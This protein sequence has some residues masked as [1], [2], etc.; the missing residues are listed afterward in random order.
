VKGGERL[1][2]ED[3]RAVFP[4]R[5]CAVSL[6]PSRRSRAA[7]SAGTGLRHV[8]SAHFVPNYA[9]CHT[10]LA[11]AGP[12]PWVLSTV[13]KRRHAC[14]PREAAASTCRRDPF[15]H[16]AADL[17]HIRPDVHDAAPRRVRARARIALITF[18]YG[19]DRGLFFPGPAPDPRRNQSARRRDR[20]QPQAGGRCTTSAPVV[21]A[22]AALRRRLSCGA[23][24][25]SQVPGPRR[26]RLAEAPT[27]GRE[28]VAVVTTGVRRAGIRDMRFVSR[29]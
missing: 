24:S 10:A 27:A 21:D 28:P 13:G 22:F 9:G 2:P 18:Y 15:R 3:Q 4:P 26:A 20:L 7:C 6:S 5:F 29:G 8:V 19:V 23:P 17:H 1:S 16:P 25:R 12:H 11:L 14:S